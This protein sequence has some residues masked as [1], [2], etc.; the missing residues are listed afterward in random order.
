[1][2]PPADQS[3]VVT[4]TTWHLAWARPDEPGAV[5]VTTMRHPAAAAAAAVPNPDL[6]PQSAT[7]AH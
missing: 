6:E 1:M 2:S 4:D 5:P 3:L 7:W